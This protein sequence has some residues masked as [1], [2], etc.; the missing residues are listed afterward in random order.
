MGI[1]GSAFSSFDAR[2]KLVSEAIESAS[3]LPLAR[4]LNAL[5]NFSVTEGLRPSLPS[6]SIM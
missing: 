1:P 2:S 4:S 6:G 5:L 3:A